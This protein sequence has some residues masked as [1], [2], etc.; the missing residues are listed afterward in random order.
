M[1]HAV[2][3]Q[4]GPCTAPASC[5]ILFCLITASSATAQEKPQPGMYEITTSL[6][7]ADLPI[8]STTTTTQN[9]MTQ[10]DLDTNPFEV[11][12]GQP[13]AQNCDMDD[14][15]MSDGNITMGMRCAD[16]NSVMSMKTAGNYD[17]SSYT[18]NSEIR[19]SQGSAESKMQS[20]VEANRVGECP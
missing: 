2:G 17:A 7:Y 6:D 8:P 3:F 11:F 12:A 20:T 4:S 19:I 14:L 9:C 13:E 18:L 10:E 16:S 5:F 15:V 1:R